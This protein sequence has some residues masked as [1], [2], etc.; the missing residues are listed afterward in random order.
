MSVRQS[1]FKTRGR[2]EGGRDLETKL[3]TFVVLDCVITLELMLP[4]C[5]N[6]T[7]TALTA[8]GMCMV[9]FSSSSMR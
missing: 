9:N 4:S 6:M 5:F 2:R 7:S 1:R 8:A 3:Q